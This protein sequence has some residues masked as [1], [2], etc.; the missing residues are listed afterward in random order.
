MAHK[1]S[2][3][4]DGFGHSNADTWSRIEYICASPQVMVMSKKEVHMNR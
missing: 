3:H 4:G 1:E 2:S